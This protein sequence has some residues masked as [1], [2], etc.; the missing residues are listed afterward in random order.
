MLILGVCVLSGTIKLRPL[1]LSVAV[2]LG[3][4]FLS[5][6]ISD[7]SLY[8]RLNLPAFAPPLSVLGIA[9]PLICVAISYAFYRV[10]TQNSSKTQKS[11]VL[12]LYAVGMA[13]GFLW[14][15]I[16]RKSVV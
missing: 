14:S 8:G 12:T 13:F 7:T 15:P 6:C 10:A 3:V 5:S 4:W 2:S 1:I 11:G 16:D 9:C